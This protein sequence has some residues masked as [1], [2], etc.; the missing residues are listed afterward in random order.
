MAAGEVVGIIKGLADVVKEQQAASK[1]T[2]STTQQQIQ[3]L[4]AAV[5]A[6]SDTVATSGASNSTLRLPQ[7]TLPEFTGRE[8]LNRFAEQLMNVLASSGVSAKFWF[9]YLK[10]QCRKDARAFDIVCNYETSNA[11]KIHEKTSNDEYLA[12]YDK[13]LTRL[14]TQRGIPKEQQIRQLLSTYCSMSQQKLESVADFAHRFLET[15]HCL[16][17]LIPGIH[18]AGGDIELMHAFMLKLQP[19]LSKNLISRDSSFS[20]LTAVIQAAKRF[21]SVDFQQQQELANSWTPQA[22]VAAQSTPRSFSKHSPAKAHD[23]KENNVSAH[24]KDNQPGR[25][26]C[27]FYNKFDVA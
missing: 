24:H 14:T 9:T 7:L 26:I 12:F 6:L 2:F 18:R 8:D 1:D 11:S 20:S 16:E 27:R 10:Q 25:R 3:D 4:S 17:K 5:Q 15:Q 22:V 19:L 13:C 23:F 21:E